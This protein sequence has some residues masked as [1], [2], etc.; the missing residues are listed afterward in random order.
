MAVAFGFFAR[1]GLKAGL[2]G[3]NK[4]LASKHWPRVAATIVTAEEVI[5][6]SR[7]GRVMRGHEVGYEYLIGRTTVR[8]SWESL[9]STS[10]KPG[11]CPF[12]V[13][14]KI[15]VFVD[16]QNERESRLFGKVTQEDWLPVAAGALFGIVAVGAAIGFFCALFSSAAR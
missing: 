12:R 6:H 2:P 5:R 11:S 10:V 16:P 8:G 15:E 3:L 7:K 1:L 14:D 9:A 4:G 13:G